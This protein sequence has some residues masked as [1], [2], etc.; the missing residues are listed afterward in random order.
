MVE[1]VNSP[2]DLRRNTCVLK[3]WFES[4][5]FGYQSNFTNSGVYEIHLFLFSA[6]LTNI[7]DEILCHNKAHI[8][9]QLSHML[10]VHYMLVSKAF[11]ISWLAYYRVENT[12]FFHITS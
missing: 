8:W 1:E 2:V 5:Y 6:I 9:F 4:W 3:S 11:T 7:Y 10:A 12:L